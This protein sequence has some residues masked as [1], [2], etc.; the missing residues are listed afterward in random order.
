MPGG[1]LITRTSSVLTVCLCLL[2]TT[3]QLA[4]AS[5][6]RVPGSNSAGA[7]A[8]AT[9]IV[10]PPTP[11]PTE[12][13][14]SD[15]D[16]VATVVRPKPDARPFDNPA[17]I[18]KT[19][20]AKQESTRV[21]G[22][23]RLDDPILRWLPEIV[24]ASKSTA[25]PA[26]I[27]AAIIRVES[28]GDPNVI[29]PAG[30][31]GLMQIMPSELYAVGFPES[32]WHDPASNVLAGA[33]VLVGRLGSYGNWNDAIGSYFGFGCDIW[34]TCTATYVGVVLTWSAYYAP[35]IADP[36][37]AGFNVLGPDWLPPPVAPYVRP[38]PP[39][40]ETPTPSPTPTPGQSKTPFPGDTPPPTQKPDHDPTAIPTEA[41][42]ALP[43]ATP[44]IAPTNTPVPVP[45]E[46]PPPPTE[47]PT[48]PPP[49]PTEQ[50]TAEGG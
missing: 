23:P 46:P 25:V 32:T 22:P 12:A 48:A 21:P 16:V 37:H 49:P 47:V 5:P 7:T 15:P 4:L 43:T 45:T 2:F 33:D 14:T 10:P 9:A 38:G 31:H 27:I 39:S 29:S 26:E 17:A 1:A 44:T 36:L 34:G 40:T 42:S 3:S 11:M 41:P 19:K 28:T 8:T 24:V 13:L 30:A 6:V 18:V 20:K 50:P 35:I